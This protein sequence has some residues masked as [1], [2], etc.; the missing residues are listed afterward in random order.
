MDQPTGPV[1]VD[2]ASCRCALQPTP[3]TAPNDPNSSEAWRCIGDSTEDMYSGNSGKWFP[4][5]DE[6]LNGSLDDTDVWGGDPPDTTEPYVAEKNGAATSYTPLNSTDS[7]SLSLQDQACTGKNDT[8]QS[9]QYYTSLNGDPLSSDARPC[10][11]PGASPIAIQNATSWN[12]TGCNLGF[13]CQYTCYFSPVKLLQHTNESYAGEHNSIVR[14]PQFCPPVPPC[15]H[16]RLAGG[17]CVPAMGQLEPVVCQQ[18]NYCPPGGQE[19][20]QCPAGHFCSV[21]AY[22]PTPCSVGSKCP[23]GTSRDMSFLPLGLLVLIDC[24]LI[25]LTAIPG[26]LAFFMKRRRKSGGSRFSMRKAASFIDRDQKNKQY[27]WLEGGD[28][29]PLE[30]RISTVQ[31]TDT[32]FGGAGDL[33]SNERFESTD[34][35]TTDLQL[36]IQSMAKCIGGNNFGLSFGFKDLMFQPKKASRPI[37]SEVTGLIERGSFS[38]VMGASGAGKCKWII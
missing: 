24:L 35:P 1:F 37:L 23:P 28:D 26:V 16:A 30:A 8:Q 15:Q 11:L 25:L 34:K 3:G 18:G 10:L 22:K 12:Q 14:L 29:L 32:G 27:Q 20:I 33:M 4:P 9:E 31:R 13:F 5:Q 6:G 7:S 2:T 17:T 21:G 19:Q 38:G 36:F